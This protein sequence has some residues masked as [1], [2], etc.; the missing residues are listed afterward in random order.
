[1]I[2]EVIDA[3]GFARKNEGRRDADRRLANRRLQP[4]GHLTATRTLSIREALSCGNPVVART[5]SEI[6]LDGPRPR[7]EL[8]PIRPTGSFKEN[9][10]VF[11]VTWHLRNPGTNGDFR[12]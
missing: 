12:R 2:E 10:A 3:R 5:V 7:T 6:V 4:L 8:R 1:M 11:S 9:A